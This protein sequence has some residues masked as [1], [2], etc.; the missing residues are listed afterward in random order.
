MAVTNQG[1]PKFKFFLPGTNT[2]AVGAKLF[3]YEVNTTTKKT[4]Y[5][6]IDIGTANTNPIILDAN[7]ECDLWLDG[8]TKLVLAPSNDIDP[9]ASPYWT[10]DDLGEETSDTDAVTNSLSN[11]S[12]EIDTNS[13]GTPDD[14]TLTPE[15]GNTLTVDS[16]DSLHGSKSLKFVIAS[17]NTSVAESSYFE[18][19]EG[20]V[21]TLAFAL[22]A[23]TAAA[24]VVMRL[25]WYDEDK[26]AISDSD[27]YSNSS[28]N[29]TSWTNTIAGFTP[30]SG[31]RFAKLQVRIAA[32]GNTVNVDNMRISVFEEKD[33]DTTITGEW[34]FTGG[35]TRFGS[36]TDGDLWKTTYDALEVGSTGAISGNTTQL[37]LSENAYFDNTDSQ[38]EYKNTDLASLIDMSAGEITLK[39]AASGTEDTAIT[40]IEG[41]KVDVDGHNYLI[42]NLSVGHPTMHSWGSTFSVTQVG[43]AGAIYALKAGGTGITTSGNAYHDGTVERYIRTSQASKYAQSGGDHYF[44]SASSGTAGNPITFTN[45]MKLWANGG[46]VIDNPTG[47]TK[48]AG[49]VNAENGFYDNGVRL[50]PL[51]TAVTNFTATQ[52]TRIRTT[53]TI[54]PS[55]D[56]SG[57]L[58]ASTSESIGPTG[59]GAT[60]IWADLD[61]IPATAVAVI[62]RASAVAD[63]YGAV[64]TH[65]ASAQLRLG[66]VGS[67]HTTCARAESSAYLDTTS[68]SYSVHAEDR[69]D[70][71]IP[72]DGS[73]VFEANWA[74]SYL[75]NAGTATT[76]ADCAL[77]LVGWMD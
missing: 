61:D 58:P 2:L 11:G 16:T 41:L 29:P 71:I 3:T 13:N 33:A 52:Y 49:T 14:W 21:G 27:A 6:D 8:K 53:T 59:S 75:V 9:P 65:K 60:N 43:E 20:L 28:S 39:V 46:L 42:N 10:I 56:V 76:A 32:T 68:S 66:G 62:L 19:Q 35:L 25:K 51:P 26:V 22:K 64:A 72:L 36:L 67:T 37:L 31:A 34:N 54:L 57:T 4:T 30:V 40:W 5:T 70:V 24:N 18:I 63:S 69:N 17:A 50:D 44:Y 55:F 7:G 45:T 12:V 47:G 73:N 77:T 48:G 1:Y 23:S 74:E 15:T 38:W